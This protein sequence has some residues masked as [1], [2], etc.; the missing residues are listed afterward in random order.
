MRGPMQTRRWQR[1]VWRKPCRPDLQRRDNQ[2]RD[3]DRRFDCQYTYQG[4][5]NRQYQGGKRLN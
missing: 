1:W 3:I 4:L 2:L 5:D